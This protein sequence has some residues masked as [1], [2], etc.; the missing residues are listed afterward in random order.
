MDL[1]LSK[2]CAPQ[3]SPSVSSQD[4]LSSNENF[5]TFIRKKKSPENRLLELNMAIEESEMADNS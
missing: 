3:K 4:L 2:N 1:K 5:K